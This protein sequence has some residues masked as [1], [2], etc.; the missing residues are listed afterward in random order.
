MLSTMLRGI[1]RIVRCI[2]MAT[3]EQGNSSS[4]ATKGLSFGT[5]SHTSEQ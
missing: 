1:R 2:G 5:K 3:A 4:A